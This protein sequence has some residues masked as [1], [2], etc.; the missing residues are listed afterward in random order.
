M[1]ENYLWRQYMVYRYVVLSHCYSV[2]HAPRMLSRIGPFY[3]KLTKRSTPVV[4]DSE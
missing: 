1:C 3:D 4:H 2:K